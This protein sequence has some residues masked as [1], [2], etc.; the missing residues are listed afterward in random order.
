MSQSFCVSSSAAT[1]RPTFSLLK[2]HHPSPP[3]VTL[4]SLSRSPPSPSSLS[5]SSSTFNPLKLR[6]P[7]GHGGIGSMVKPRTSNNRSSGFRVLCYARPFAPPNLQWIAAVSSLVLILAKGTTV[8]KS[9]IVPLFALQAP[10]GFIAWIKGSYG[11]WAAFLAL[12]VRLFFYI[13]GELELPFLALLLVIVA[14]YEAMK[15]RDT[16]E[17]A[18]ISLLIAVYLAYQHF[19]RTSLQKSFDQGSV[20]ATLA[21]ICITLVSLMLVL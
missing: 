7:I 18:F 3:R 11:M 12:L 20:V 2:C 4:L 13:P 14:P 5:F 9:F 6:S 10:A 17:G 1:A 8:P 21:V 19:S 15:F 16:K